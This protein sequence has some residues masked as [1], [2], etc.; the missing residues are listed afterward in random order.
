MPPL[1]PSTRSFVAER[2]PAHDERA[3]RFERYHSALL[4]NDAAAIYDTAPCGLLSTDPSGT[5]TDVNQTFLTWTGHA[6]KDLVGRR[7]FAELLTP[8]G[9]IYHETHFAPMLQMQGAVREIAVD[10]VAVGGRRLPTLVNAVLDRDAD[11]RPIGVRTV[12]FDATE[13]REY[14][15]ELVRAR[16]RAEESEA[17]ANLLARTLQQ[18]LI[19]PAPPVIPGLEVAARFRPAGDGTEVG[20][21]FYDVFQIADGTWVVVVGDVCGK[22][23]EAAVVTAL[24]RYTIRAAAIRLHS[25]VE[26]LE[27]LNEV[28]QRSDTN[29]F[30][31]V[32]LLRFTQDAAEWRCTATSAGHPLPIIHHRGH[33]P[34]A[35]GNNGTLLGVFAEVALREDEV[36]LGAG[37]SI[38]VY[39]DGVT[40]AR[41][42]GKF[43]GE[44]SLHASI[45]ARQGSAESLADG[46]LADVMAYQGDDSHDDIAIVAVRTPAA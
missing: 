6:R 25:P 5:I 20:G 17:R 45:E 34:T 21:D 12:I 14:E 43:F 10:I 46:I 39:T 11:G 3:K 30:C 33:A 28:L 40:E 22:G 16:H 1:M 38:V 19:P 35:L 32:A 42:G 24:A 15:R 7:T 4:N 8:G 37:D 29:R 2:P 26:I 41:S 36:L 13:R 44:A 23:A 18:T 27:M 9:R 31:T